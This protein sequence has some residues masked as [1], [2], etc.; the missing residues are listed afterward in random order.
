[1]RRT[2][3]NA[4]AVFDENYLVGDLESRVDVVE[5]GD[6]GLTVLLQIG[7]QFR[8]FSDIFGVEIGARFVQKY[9]VGVLRQKHGEKRFT[10][11]AA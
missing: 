11:F 4:F 3:E 1:M 6:N 5:N 2:V 7:Y 9:V 10:T 8:Y